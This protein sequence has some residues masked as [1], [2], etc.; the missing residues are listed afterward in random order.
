MCASFT[1]LRKLEYIRLNSPKLI[2]LRKIKRIEKTLITA[3]SEFFQKKF[4]AQVCF[5]SVYNP[6]KFGSVRQVPSVSKTFVKVSPK[7]HIL[8]PPRVNSDYGFCFLNFSDT[9]QNIFLFSSTVS[10]NGL[11]FVISFEKQLLLVILAKHL[12]TKWWMRLES[13]IL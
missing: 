4:C 7:R 5:R 1:V 10:S 8:A 11:I 6:W 3:K 13:S 9:F 2:E 12:G